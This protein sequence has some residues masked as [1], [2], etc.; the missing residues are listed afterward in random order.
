MP[1]PMKLQ[2][3]TWDTTT[4]FDQW[5]G[6]LYAEGWFLDG[7]VPHRVAADG[8]L[9]YTFVR[10]TITIEHDPDRPEG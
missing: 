1:E 10:P 3:F 5:R 2:E 9:V 4:D 8:S 7:D 6:Q